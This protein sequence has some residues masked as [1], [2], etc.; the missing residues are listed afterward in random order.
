MS[1]FIEHGRDELLSLRADHF[2]SANARKRRSNLPDGGYSKGC[3]NLA[4]RRSWKRVVLDEG[5]DST[6][7]WL[8]SL[9]TRA[10][11]QFQHKTMMIFILMIMESPSWSS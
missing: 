7:G 2:K 1:D 11:F 4:Q 10:S 3:E 5:R 8:T 6:R 9:L